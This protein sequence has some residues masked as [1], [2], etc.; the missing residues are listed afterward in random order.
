MIQTLDSLK[1]GHFVP[2]HLNK[3]GRRPLD[4]ATYQILK[5]ER[6]GSEED[7]DFLKIFLKY[8]YLNKCLNIWPLGQGHFGPR[9]LH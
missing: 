7:F 8:K 9:G 1:R 2:H 4:D 5:S 6:S 3:F